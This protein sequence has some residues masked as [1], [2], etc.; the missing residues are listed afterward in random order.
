MRVAPGAWLIAILLLALAVQPGRAQGTEA[1]PTALTSVHDG[2]FTAEQAD[3]GAQV[4]EQGCGR[5]HQPEQF[6]GPGFMGAWAGQ[7][8]DVLFELIRT[9]MPEDNPSSLRR[10]E[11][12]DILAFLFRLNGMPA[13]E[14]AL[15]GTARKLKLIRIDAPLATEN[16]P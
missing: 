2:V 12:T 13:G 1:A 9:T 8:A 3:R 6:M 4:F 15:P 7:T 14:T 11:Y 5:C 10:K 16:K